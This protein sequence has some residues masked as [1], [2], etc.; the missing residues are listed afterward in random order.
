MWRLAVCGLLL[1][2]ITLAVQASEDP[3]ESL[4]GVHD[5]S[6]YLKL[7]MG[8]DDRSADHSVYTYVLIGCKGACVFSGVSLCINSV[9]LSV[10]HI[11]H[12]H[13][14]SEVLTCLAVERYRPVTALHNAP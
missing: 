7:S 5:L 8:L 14:S 2:A 1:G 10:L 13:A 4:A 9:L 11:L 3:T 12:M 6:K